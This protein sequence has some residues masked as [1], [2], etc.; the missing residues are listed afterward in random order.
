VAQL[1]K[2]RLEEQQNKDAVVAAAAIL[3]PPASVSATKS[4]IVSL[5]IPNYHHSNP[6]SSS[7]IAFPSPFPVDPPSPNLMIRPPQPVQ[8]ILLRNSTTNSGEF[9]AGWSGISVPAVDPG[10]AFWSNLN[11]PYESDIPVWPPA[12]L[13]FPRTQ[14]YQQP[15]PSMVTN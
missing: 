14:Q 5:P 11:L 2:I 7:N 3:S 10:L 15:P 12:G 4:S 1:E 6:S 13:N 8:N 9:D